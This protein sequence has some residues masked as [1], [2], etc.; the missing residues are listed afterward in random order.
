VIQQNASAAEEMAST[1]EE[2][3]SQSEQL[4]ATIAFFRTGA[5]GSFQVKPKRKPMALAHK[6]APP[7]TKGTHPSARTRIIQ[8]RD[9]RF[10]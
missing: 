4:Q 7:K 9:D 6:A 5:E 1:S 3:S 10:R 2:L 8:R